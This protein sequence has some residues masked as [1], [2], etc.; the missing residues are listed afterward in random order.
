V[1]FA[2]VDQ[3]QSI[4]IDMATFKKCKNVSGKFINETTLR[5]AVK[6]C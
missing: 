6:M 2:E 1:C 5:K 4:F 3:V